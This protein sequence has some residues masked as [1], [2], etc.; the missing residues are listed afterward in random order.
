MTRDELLVELALARRVFDDKVAAVPADAVRDEVPG[1]GHSIAQLVAHIAQYDRL[2]VDRLESAGHGAM[3]ELP[4]DR[5]PQ[6]YERTT[7]TFADGWPFDQVMRRAHANFETLVSRMREVEDD[8]LSGRIG[9]GGVLD[10]TWL[11][12][13]PP[14]RAILDDTASHYLEHEPMLDAALSVQR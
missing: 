1:F 7:W 12:G 14:W 2:V 6:G 9:A 8:E 11:R 5:D 4:A 10:R 13:R 3:T